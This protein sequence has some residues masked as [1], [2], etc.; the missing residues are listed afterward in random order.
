ML[1]EYF[2]QKGQAMVLYALMLPVMFT[3]VGVAA[4]FG[5]WYFNES[6]LQNAADAAVLAGAKVIAQN[7]TK[8][9]TVNLISSD[10]QTFIEFKK[11]KTPMKPINQEVI[12]N[13][14]IYAEANLSDDYQLSSDLYESGNENSSDPKYY[15]VTLTSKAEHLFNIMEK[16]GE[17]NTKAEAVAKISNSVVI[18]LDPP[19]EAEPE[20]IE[21]MDEVKLGN[22]IIG[23]WEIQNKYHNDK[24]NFKK[25]YGNIYDVEGLFDGK[26]N[27][28]KTPNKKITNSGKIFREENLIVKSGSENEFD[29]PANG[30]KKYSSQELESINIDFTQDISIKL[31]AGVKKLTEDWDIGDPEPTEQIDSISVIN[32]GSKT[33]RTHS[34]INFDEPYQKRDGKESY[35]VLWT[36]I[37]SEPMWYNLGFQD[38]AQLNTVRQIIININKSNMNDNYRPLG[39]FYD[40]P[41]TN[42]NNPNLTEDERASVNPIRQSQPVILNLNAD[43]SGMLYM[44]NIPVVLNGNG[45]KFKG[46]IIAKE[47]LSLKTDSDFHNVNGRYYDDEGKECFKITDSHNQNNNMFVDSIGNVQ[48]KSAKT[49]SKYGDY[50]AFGVTEFTSHNYQVPQAS[51]DNL[52]TSGI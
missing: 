12:E 41:E 27:H 25:N 26:W 28:Y 37:E 46:F 32:N 34:Q 52:F 49:G 35:D 2:K 50:S 18:K 47:Y 1:K 33:V 11:D 8:N 45:H 15:V 7:D 20:L 36:R 10:D 30:K 16:F 6:K 9:D 39:I 29:T 51:A 24:N 4:D 38:Q 42:S 31:K 40:G 43:F 3:F 23:N 14:N 19:E 13:T 5:W 22:V 44:P 48:Y 17:M 21:T